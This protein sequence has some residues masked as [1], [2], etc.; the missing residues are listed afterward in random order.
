MG[1]RAGLMPVKGMAGQIQEWGPGNG[2]R[3]P[4]F[5]I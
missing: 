2:A 3:P 5:N 4:A 1:G